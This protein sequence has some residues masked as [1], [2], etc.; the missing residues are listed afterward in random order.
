MKFLSVRDLRAQSAQV[1][2]DLSLEKEMV[3]T[4][5]GRPVAVLASVDEET[6]ESSLNAWRQAKATRAI[7]SIQNESML[8]GT[9]TLTIE[10]IE[11]EITKARQ[12]RSKHY[13]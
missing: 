5:N 1:W 13:S 2:K 11:T 6:V 10:D 8:S 7:V 12:E 3:I 9:N 4:N